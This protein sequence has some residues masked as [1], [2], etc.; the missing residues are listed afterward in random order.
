MLGVKLTQEQRG[1]PSAGG[2]RASQPGCSGHSPAEVTSSPRLHGP[3]G[4]VPGTHTKLRA[5]APAKPTSRKKGREPRMEVITIMP[6]LRLPGHVSMAAKGVAAD[7][8][9]VTPRATVGVLLPGCP[10]PR[11]TGGGERAQVSAGLLPLPDFLA[12]SSC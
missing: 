7:D 12:S 5:M 1:A 3:H 9:W 8:G 10:G 11:G 4:G 6:P 2:V